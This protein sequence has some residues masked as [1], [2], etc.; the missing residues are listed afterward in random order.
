MVK[1]ERYRE[2][3]QK[4]LQDYAA[5]SRNYTEI[6]TQLIFDVFSQKNYRN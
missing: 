1:L 6:E 4:L 2:N 3:I 5:F